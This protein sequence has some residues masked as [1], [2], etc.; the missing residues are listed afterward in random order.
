MGCFRSSVIS[1]RH[2]TSALENIEILKQSPKMQSRKVVQMNS[3][4]RTLA[5]RFSDRC[6]IVIEDFLLQQSVFPENR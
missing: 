1:N 4:V 5:A 6:A 3:L 2:K